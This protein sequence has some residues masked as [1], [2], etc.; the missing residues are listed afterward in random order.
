MITDAVD[1]F[2]CDIINISAGL[3]LDKPEVREAILYAE[4][5]GI[6]VVASAGNDY[7]KTEAFKYYPAGYESVLAVGSINAEK[8]EISG[9]SQRGE[10]VDVFAVGEE[11]T[12]KTLSGNTRQSEGTSYSAAKVTAFAANI[13]KKAKNEFSAEELRQEVLKNCENLP[14]GTKYIP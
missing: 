4:E 9:F 8:T 2:G 12:V 3:V 14:D 5:N 1:V 13:L 6:L 11:V 7:E 10:W